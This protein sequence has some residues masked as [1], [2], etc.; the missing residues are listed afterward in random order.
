[1]SSNSTAERMIV[2]DAEIR[3]TRYVHGS[4]RHIWGS[5]HLPPKIKTNYWAFISRNPVVLAPSLTSSSS[6]YPGRR[7]SSKVAVFFKH[8]RSCSSPLHL[9]PMG[10]HLQSLGLRTHCMEYGVEPIPSGFSRSLFSIP[11]HTISHELRLSHPVIRPN[12]LWFPGKVEITV[13]CQP[14]H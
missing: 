8:P 10:R 1:M 14:A 5:I 13:A 7:L 9:R 6:V 11:T 12:P 3:A 2:D 4:V